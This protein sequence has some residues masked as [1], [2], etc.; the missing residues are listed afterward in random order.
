MENKKPWLSKTLWVS[1]IIAVAPF[2]PV[3]GLVVT[4]NPQAV[5]IVVG[6]IFAALRLSTDT[7]ISAK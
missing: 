7:G 5:S 1:A 3:V 2:I 6:L 4:A